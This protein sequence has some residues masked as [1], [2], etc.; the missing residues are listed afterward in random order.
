MIDRDKIVAA[1]VDVGELRRDAFKLTPKISPRVSTP[2]EIAE[3]EAQLALI[4]DEMQYRVDM[5]KE[6]FG[7][8]GHD[9]TD[10]RGCGCD[11]CR[12]APDL[13]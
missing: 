7:S 4:V 10:P 3:V 9:L 6:A 2:S 5:M 8:D 12:N 1:F 11:S 13:C